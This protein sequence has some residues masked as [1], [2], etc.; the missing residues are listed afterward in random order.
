MA[1]WAKH[2]QRGTHEVGVG[3]DVPIHYS[4]QPEDIILSGMWVNAE[5]VVDGHCISRIVIGDN[6]PYDVQSK[7]TPVDLDG[8]QLFSY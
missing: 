7:S 8:L 6:D 1:E 2:R 3:G 5:A 4:K